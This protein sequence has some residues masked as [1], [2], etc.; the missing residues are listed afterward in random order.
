MD[1]EKLKVRLYHEGRLIA[2]V[3]V[4]D[5]NPVMDIKDAAAKRYLHDGMSLKDFNGFLSRRAFPNR[6]DQGTADALRELGLPRYDLYEILKKTHGVMLHD[7]ISL[8]LET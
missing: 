5:G 7:K 6:H 8:D 2:S 4:I 1:G 3:E